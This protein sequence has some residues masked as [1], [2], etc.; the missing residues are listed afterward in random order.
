MRREGR[1]MRRAGGSEARHD[2]MKTAVIVSLEPC[3]SSI[4]V[5]V[6]QGHGGKVVVA[7][8]V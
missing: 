6:D 5:I 4:V 2:Y 7:M 3:P 8:N 1:G